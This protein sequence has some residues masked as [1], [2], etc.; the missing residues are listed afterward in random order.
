ML[1]PGQIL[2]NRYQL[3]KQLGQNSSRHTWLAI[4]L[5]S[6]EQ[7]VLKL[8]TLNPQMQWDEHKLFE[9]EVQVLKNLNHPRIPKYRDFFIIDNLSGSRFPWF[10]LVQSYITGAS[11]QELLNQGHRFSESQVEKIAI[12]ILSILVYLHSLKPPV[13]HRD[14]KPSNLIL[15]EDER[16]HLVDFGAVQDKAVA[17]GVTFTVVGTYGYVPMEQFAGRAVPASDLYAL[18]ATLIHLITGTTPADLPHQNS[19]IEFANLVSIDL[20]LINWIGKLTE[21]N[22]AERISTAKNAIAA[23]ENKQTLSPPITTRKPIGSKIQ[24]KKTASYLE[25]KLPKRGSKSLRFFYLIGL[26]LPFLPQVVNIVINTSRFWNDKFTIGLFLLFVI[27]LILLSLF[28]HTDLYFDRE[29]F[30]I[31]WKLFGLCYWRKRGKTRAIEEIYQQNTKAASA[32]M[33][34]TIELIK[35]Q[36]FTTTPLATIERYWLMDEI[37]DWLKFE[38][39]KGKNGT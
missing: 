27:P 30:E 19:R 35:G 28:G 34:I 9:R 33:G 3:Q 38:V 6:Q 1:E 11:L 37:V 31:K 32:P 15:G 26:V 16:V 8:L 22:I 17:E 7:V 5:S 21:P 18:G 4:L 13:L 12:E 14:I 10:V 29:D 20:G 25:I 23:L 36:K 39:D 24:L 2:D